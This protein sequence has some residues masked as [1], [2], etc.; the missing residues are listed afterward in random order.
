MHK[1]NLRQLGCHLPSLFLPTGPGPWP[2]SSVFGS[3]NLMMM[4]QSSG[5][6]GVHLDLVLNFPSGIIDWRAGR[7]EGAPASAHELYRTY[8]EIQLKMTMT[9]KKYSAGHTNGAEFCFARSAF[10]SLWILIWSWRNMEE[11]CGRTGE[12]CGG[13]GFHLESISSGFNPQV[14]K[15]LNSLTGSLAMLAHPR[16]IPI[17]TLTQASRLH[18][19]PSRFTQSP[20]KRSGVGVGNKPKLLLKHGITWSC[21]C[22]LSQ[23][24]ATSQEDGSGFGTVRA[25]WWYSSPAWMAPRLVFAYEMFVYTHLFLN[26]NQSCN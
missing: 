13:Q 25:A 26:I 21:S 1:P 10:S 19:S 2:L 7:R 5:C 20:C 4:S 17:L 22:Q 12:W 9:L 15:H 23:A 8:W 3:W 18:S 14:W 6:L 24:Y 16:G 11:E